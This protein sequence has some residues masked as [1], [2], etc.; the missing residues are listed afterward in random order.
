VN[1]GD[2]EVGLGEVDIQPRAEEDSGEG[3]M[4]Q[5]AQTMRAAKV[6][7]PWAR[8]RVQLKTL[9]AEGRLRAW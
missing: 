6:M 3:P 2:D 8:V 9:T 4:K 1:A 7:E 5:R